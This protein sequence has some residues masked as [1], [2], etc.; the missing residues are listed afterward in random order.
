[1]NTLK[2]ELLSGGD[3][4]GLLALNR[5][6]F[7][8]ATMAKGY[9]SFADV[10]RV[11]ADGRDFNALYAEFQAA[12]AVANEQQQRFIDLLT[13]PTSSPVVSVLQTLGTGDFA[14]EE[15]SEYGVP[16]SKRINPAT[17]DMGATFKWYDNRWGATWQYL[18]DVSAGEL[19]AA[20]N[21]ILSADADLVFNKVM[22]TVFSEDNRTVT[23]PKT[24][25]SYTVHS[26]ANGDAW[27]PP[28]Y[29]ANTFDGTHTHYRTSGAA[30]IT[31]GD[32]D[33]II[34]D[35]KSHGYSAENGSQIVIFVNAAEGDV[36]NGFR[37]ATG[38]KADFIP[39]QG[40]RFYSANQLVGDQPTATFAGFPVKGGYDE[41]LIVESSRIPAGYIA[42]LVS[43]GSNLPSN[44][45][46]LREHKRLK[47]LQLVG[48][49]NADYPLV[50]SYWVRG[51][52]T[53]VRHRLAG[54]V[55]QVTANVNY[56]APAL[57]AA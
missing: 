12:A 13:Y 2:A 44:P 11:T 18:A 37:V 56:T 51:F 1:M 26:F 31:A 43:G 28:T 27:V 33:E 52:G 3:V 45:I 32:L 54:M 42:T 55:M 14:F 5:Q 57:Y 29:A 24:N 10:M 22:G 6:T 39:A 20:T 9:S 21:A 40:A 16:Q 8:M 50:D 36:I 47:G 35:F 46:M 7:G 25:T 48:G 38:A 17:L 49:N 19:A 23:D 41:A 34:A 30:V 4:A 53:G 15:A